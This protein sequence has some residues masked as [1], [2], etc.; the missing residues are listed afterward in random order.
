MGIDVNAT[1][2]AGGAVSLP[3]SH[4][5][6]H[7]TA[8]TAAQCAAAMTSDAVNGQVIVADDNGATRSYLVWKSG[9]AYFYV[10]GTKAT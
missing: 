10:A 8:P 6:V 4:D 2:G 7:D 5:D 1:C 9:G 3:V